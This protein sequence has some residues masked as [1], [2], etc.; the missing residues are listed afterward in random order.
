MLAPLSDPAPLPGAAGAPA[1]PSRGAAWFLAPGRATCISLP[2]PAG[3][4]IEIGPV[5]NTVR[6]LPFMENGPHYVVLA[7]SQSRVR[8]FRAS[9]FDI[10]PLPVPDMPKSLE[11]ALWYI[12]R[13]PTF[14]RHGS[15]MMHA[16]GGGPQYHK[17]DIH[18]YL[19]MVDRALGPVLV[20]VGYEAAMFVNESHYRHIV[21]TPV[22]GNADTLDV[23]TIHERTWAVA[24]ALP[25]AAQAAAARARE[26]AGTGRAVT[27]LTEVGTAAV[28][29]A[30]DQLIVA[31]SATDGDQ[32]QGPLGEDRSRLASALNAA[33]ANGA[34]AHVVDDD[35]L[36]DGALAVAILR[37]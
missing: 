36:P 35:E 9:R 5:P 10:A 24:S 8:V 31:R 33:L 25:G 30:V 22:V 11:D 7:I 1:A 19:H 27:D 37:Y 17:D 18:Q 15:G 32:V 23:A 2:G 29:G 16:S 34:T 21:P 3:P 14:Q 13:E 4:S 12:Q 28:S 20:G 26:L 6:L